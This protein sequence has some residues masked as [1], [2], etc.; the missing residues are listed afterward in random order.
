MCNYEI[1]LGS[2]SPRRIAM[3][4]TCGYSLQ[5]CPPQVEE[6]IPFVMT[7]S[8]TALYLS[9]K[10]GRAVLNSRILS[11]NQVIVSADTLV[12]FN[13]L[14]IGK[15]KDKQDALSML[16][17]L[18][19]KMHKVITGVTLTNRL[20][21]HCFYDETKV[22]FKAYSSQDLTRY[23]STP[24]PY[25]KAGGYGAQGTFQKFISHIEGEINNVI[26][27]PMTRFLKELPLFMNTFI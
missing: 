6:T 20:R 11:H 14:I 15:P 13:G 26:G 22:F 19:G 21:S 17:A 12:S 23:L 27:F 8:A 18:S 25:D 7:P 1:I 3:F 2:G 5:V 9:L 4:Q 10:K 24:E 16:M